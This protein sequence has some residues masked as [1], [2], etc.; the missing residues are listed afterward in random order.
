[1][2]IIKIRFTAPDG[3]EYV[4]GQQVSSEIAKQYPKYV[5]DV[6]QLVVEKIV[7]VVEE[8]EEEIT[9]KKTAKKIAKK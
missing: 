4:P 3:T 5:K 9:V 2:I 7:E 1:M 6:P 8:K